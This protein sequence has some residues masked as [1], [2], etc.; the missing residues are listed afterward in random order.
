MEE[1]KLT[2]LM[3]KIK[4]LFNETYSMFHKSVLQ[5]KR[6][7]NYFEWYSQSIHCHP[8]KAHGNVAFI[9]Q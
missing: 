8:N 3:K 5:Q 7:T 2:R 9:S 6:L 1:Q 4:T